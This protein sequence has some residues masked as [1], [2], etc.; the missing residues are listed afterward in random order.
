MQSQ[1]SMENVL[2]SIGPFPNHTFCAEAHQTSENSG[3]A[4]SQRPP[5]ETNPVQPKP[6]KLVG[7]HGTDTSPELRKR[8]Q[9]SPMHPERKSDGENMRHPGSHHSWESELAF[10]L[11]FWAMSWTQMDKLGLPPTGQTHQGNNARCH[12]LAQCELTTDDLFGAGE[13]NGNWVKVAYYLLVFPHHTRFYSSLLGPTSI[14]IIHCYSLLKR[15]S[16]CCIETMTVVTN[17]NCIRWGFAQQHFKLKS[18]Q[19]RTWTLQVYIFI[20]HSI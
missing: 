2:G 9:T 5:E 19:V 8:T 13:E 6:L 3:F 11:K 10:A 4:T 17:R 12:L 7:L 1:F 16:P 15:P 14:L 20:T 18:H